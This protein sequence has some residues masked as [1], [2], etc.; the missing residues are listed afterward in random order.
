MRDDSRAARDLDQDEREGD[1]NAG[2]AIDHFVEERVARVVVVRAVAA[3]TELVVE[4][5]EKVRYAR[6]HDGLARCRDLPRA[7]IRKTSA[8][9]RAEIVEPLEVHGHVELRVVGLGEKQR[10]TR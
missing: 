9:S 10:H 5:V 7:W 6:R 4:Q 1:R 2:A 3:K 8:T